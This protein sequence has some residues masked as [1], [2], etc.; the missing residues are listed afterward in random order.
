MA[1]GTIEA[2]MTTVEMEQA[3]DVTKITIGVW[4]NT[5]GLPYIEIPGNK[6]P[7]IRFRPRDVEAWAARV[8]KP[9]HPPEHIRDTLDADRERVQVVGDDTD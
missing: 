4:R 8:G 7:A 3:F 2:L 6:R 1:A 5:L 9:F